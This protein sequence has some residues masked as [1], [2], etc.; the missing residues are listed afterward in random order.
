MDKDTKD[1]LIGR[2]IIMVA[3]LVSRFVWDFVSRS[4]RKKK[5]N[6]EDEN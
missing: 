6:K 2:A 5:T 1:E 4:F 3:G